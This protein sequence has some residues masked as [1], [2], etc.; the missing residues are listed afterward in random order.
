MKSGRLNSM[1]LSSL[2]VVSTVLAGTQC[3][4]SGVNLLQ[5]GIVSGTVTLVHP[6]SGGVVADESTRKCKL[7]SQ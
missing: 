6:C 1:S 2:S 3:I 4:D 7:M 5:S